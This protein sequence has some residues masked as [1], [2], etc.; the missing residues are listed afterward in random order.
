MQLPYKT[1]KMKGEVIES[2]FQ[3]R[4]LRLGFTVCKPWGDSA[5]SDFI[6]VRNKPPKRVQV[7]STWVKDRNS[8]LVNA[9]RTGNRYAYSAR[10]VDYLIACIVMPSEE[11][12]EAKCQ[13]TTSTSV[14]PKG[15]RRV[16]ASAPA[17][18]ARSTCLQAATLSEAKGSGGSTGLHAGEK[19]RSGTSALAPVDQRGPGRLEMRR[20]APA[21]GRR[22]KPALSAVEGTAD[23][24]L[25]WYII[26]IRAL[27]GKKTIAVFPHAPK[28][29]KSRWEKYRENWDLLG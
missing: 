12:T 2:E 20:I 6:V 23:R 11:D 19:T 1:A 17:T 26:P 4:A 13:G 18:P 27:R 5:S 7:K 24:R 21:T 25:V 14:V 22:P 9:G 3:T 8:Y 15:A 29:S 16:R 10:K 28:G